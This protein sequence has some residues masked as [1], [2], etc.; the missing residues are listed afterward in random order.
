MLN[1]LKV[2]LDKLLLDYWWR[3][4]FLSYDLRY[5]FDFP[6]KRLIKYCLEKSEG[7]SIVTKVEM[8]AHMYA[9]DSTVDSNSLELI[10]DCHGTCTRER[11]RQVL[12]KYVRQNYRTKK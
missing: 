9:Y 11:V 12:A 3:I 8:I 7:N 2:K 10:H 1:N 4:P 5:K 6:T